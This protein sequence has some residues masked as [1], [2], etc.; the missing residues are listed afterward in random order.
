MH[1]AA[2]LFS[3]IIRRRLE[4]WCWKFTFASLE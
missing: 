1:K 2:H 3:L 4:Y